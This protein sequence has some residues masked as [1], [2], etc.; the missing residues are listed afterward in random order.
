MQSDGRKKSE[1]ESEKTIS[2]TLNRLK[3]AKVNRKVINEEAGQ[4]FQ[5]GSED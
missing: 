3:K 4:K 2:A 1:N 5:I